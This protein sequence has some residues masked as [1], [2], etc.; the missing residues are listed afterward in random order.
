MRTISAQEVKRRGI[1]AVDD[2]MAEG[3]VYIITHNEPRYVVMEK[4]HTKNSWKNSMSFMW[5]VFGRRLR[6]LPQERFVTSTMSMN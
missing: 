6:M 4:A 1:S 3:P 2:L 5:P